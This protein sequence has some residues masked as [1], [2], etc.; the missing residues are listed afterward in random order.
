MIGDVYIDKP[1]T[2]DDYHPEQ[3]IEVDQ[4][5][6]EQPKE[7]TLLDDLKDNADEKNRKIIIRLNMKRLV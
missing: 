6:F 2:T 3:K 4:K 5:V 7:R 1:I